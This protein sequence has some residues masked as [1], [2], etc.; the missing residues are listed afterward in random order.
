M[1]NNGQLRIVSDHSKCLSVE[2]PV[3]WN[4]IGPQGEKGDTGNT[5]PQGEVGPAGPRG[6]GAE[7]F[8]FIGFTA[9]TT[10][11]G[12]GIF[13]LNKM[14]QQEFGRSRMC[15]SEEIMTTIDLPPIT[16]EPEIIWGWVRPVLDNGTAY[17]WN[18]EDTC[19]GWRATVGWSGWHLVVNNRGQFTSRK[20]EDPYP[21]ACCSPAP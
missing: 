20:C 2:L 7:R 1:K 9:G 18:G 4:Q 10:T 21:I 19:N 5:G 15:V 13:K 8:E 12:E 16:E 17:L 11:A 3:S 14:C 6:I